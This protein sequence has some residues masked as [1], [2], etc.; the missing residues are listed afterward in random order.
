MKLKLIFFGVFLLVAAGFS[1]VLFN[2]QTY[3]TSVLTHAE[4]TR[5]PDSFMTNTHYREMDANGHIHVEIIAP[6][7][8]HYAYKNSSDF[9]A[10]NMTIYKDTKI[11]WKVTSKTGHST[12]GL[13]RIDLYDDVVIDHL[14]KGDKVP[15][16]ALNSSAFTIYPN[17]DYGETNQAVTIVK[18]GNTIKGIG[19]QANLD[20]GNI[21]LLSQVDATY[22]KQKSQ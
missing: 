13:E 16:M 9:V 10:P 12:N 2:K 7:I 20:T 4:E 11:S 6:K 21:K 8:V 14:L 17:R 18:A 3:H 15:P 22:D 1:A 5:N 19:L